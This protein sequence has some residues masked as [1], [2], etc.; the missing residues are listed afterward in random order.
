LGK[1]EHIERVIETDP[2]FSPQERQTIRKRLERHTICIGV[3]KLQ[4]F[5]DMVKEVGDQ[6]K[7]NKLICK[8]E[9]EGYA[10]PNL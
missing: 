6:N 1:A 2:G 3:K 5:L 10:T 8:L 4:G 9:E 7:V